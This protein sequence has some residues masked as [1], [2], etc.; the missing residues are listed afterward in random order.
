MLKNFW[1]ACEFSSAVTSQPKQVQMLNQRFVLYRHSQ[2]QVIALQDQCPHR[3]AA[4]SLG[5]VKDDCLHCPYHGWKF[6]AN[7]RCINIPSNGPD[8]P[9]PPQAQVK[10]YPVQEKYG[11]VWLFYGDLPEAER[12]PLPTFPADLAGM[13][14]VE[15]EAIEHASYTR[16][17]QANIDF[18]HVI[19][20][21]KKSFGQRI[22]LHTVIRYPVESDAWSAV[23]SV[24]YASLSNSKSTLNT[25]LGKRPDLTT[26]L[27]FYLPNV[28]LAEISIGKGA[29]SDIRFGIL[30]AFVPIDD[31]TTCAK[32]MLYRNV[33]PLPLLDGWVKKL[34]YKLAYEDTLVVETIP[35]Q[36]LPRI[37]AEQH[38]AADALDLTFRKLRQKYLA[39]GWGLGAQAPAAPEAELL[40]AAN[41]QSAVPSLLAH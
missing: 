29:K 22:P 36:V 39:M 2:G 8:L 15:H 41:G 5:S 18:A 35:D 12:H 26:R 27:S 3:G 10:T 25:L 9:I 16:L 28:T 24:K 34:D 21:H 32:R 13:H 1:Y 4:L 37:S 40:T 30:V 14:P 7:G 20:I 19:A 23:A 11:Y 17:M 33:L 6:Q 31:H 38:V